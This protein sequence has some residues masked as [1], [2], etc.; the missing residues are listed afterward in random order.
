MTQ[1]VLYSD[2]NQPV[3]WTQMVCPMVQFNSDTNYLELTAD[4]TDLKVQSHKT[5]PIS[6]ASCKQRAQVTLTLLG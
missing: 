2:T 6:D 3:L 1:S 5:A 4:C